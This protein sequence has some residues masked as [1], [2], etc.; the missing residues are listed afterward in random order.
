MGDRKYVELY[1]RLSNATVPDPIFAGKD[2]RGVCENLFN[3][4]HSI[5]RRFFSALP[6]C[7]R[8]DLHYRFHPLPHSELWPIVEEFSL[9]LRCCLLLLTLPHSCQK[10]FLLKCR[11]LFRILNSFLSVHVTEHRS[12]RFSNFLTDVDLDF[13][14]YCR[15]FLLALLEVFADELLRHQPLRRYLMMVDSVSSIHEKLFVC[16]FNQGD[17][18]IVL[19]VLS[20]HFI[21]SVSNEKAVEDFAVRL[22]LRCDKDFRFPE[23]SIGP[24]IVLLHDPVVLSAPKMFQA[25]IVSTVSEAIGSGLSSEPLANFQLIALQKSVILYSTHVSSLQ[26]DGFHVESKCS[27]SH[28]LDR[29]Q[30]KFE[31]YIRHGTRNRLNKVL[32]K[33]DDSW[34]SYQ[35]K[36]FSKTKTDL[37]TEYIAFMK[38]RQ[39]LFDDSLRE[40][41]TSILNCLIHQA[42]SQEATGVYTIKENTSAQDI[43]LLA[44]IL[45]MMSVSLHQAVKYLRNSG[46]SDCLKTMKSATVHGK[47]D[48]LIS[49]FDYFRQFK[50]CLPIQSFLYDEMK[51]QKSNY[52]VS[53]A[54]LVHFTGLLSLSF[55]NGLELLA[56]GCI[57]VLM[58]L[59]YLFVFEE[60]DLL[61]LES[62]KGPSLQ[63]CLSEIS[64]HKSGKGARD[65]QSV[66]EV[67]AEFRRIQSC[68]LRTDSF[69][70]CNDDN[71]TKKTCNGEMFLN[72][73]LGDPKKLSDYDELA[74]FLEC[75]TGKNYS[76]WMNR[77]EI[78]RDKR[79]QKKLEL[80]K[81]MKKTVRK[82]CRFKNNGH[83]FKGQKN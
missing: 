1:Q 77:R 37:L 81:T 74:D 11:Y 50:I 79:Y 65:N 69:T 71:E 29:G 32:S 4:L 61:A 23:L 9:I 78:Y 2:H 10:F 43:C 39:Y 46:D 55:N 40:G 82:S 21:L 28:L 45:K 73:I 64:C 70:S 52:K 60:G 63:P 15:P 33:L 68:N 19:E 48:F 83:S 75:K 8:H 3:Q 24:S 27:N 12:V 80:R 35:C 13:D 76:K 20:S 62:L 42:F 17:I 44:S 72:C 6:L 57:S 34:D 56:K 59:M 31:S 47:Y 7:H 41:I 22:F 5:F 30:L 66:Y 36:L 18:A 25:H 16:H 53:E 14:D 67:V 38:E 26:I 54:L 49:I 51:S 58:A